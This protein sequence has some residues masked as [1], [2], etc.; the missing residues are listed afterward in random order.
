MNNWEYKRYLQEILRQFYNHEVKDKLGLFAEAIN[1]RP[2]N[3]TRQNKSYLRSISS[4]L[5]S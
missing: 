1:N 2:T 4:L 5:W 3:I